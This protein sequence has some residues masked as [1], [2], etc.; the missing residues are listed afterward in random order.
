[1]N[2]FDQVELQ[3]VFEYIN[4]NLGE[5]SDETIDIANSPLYM[6]DDLS[7]FTLIDAARDLCDQYGKLLNLIDTSDPKVTYL[8]QLIIIFIKKFLIFFM[9]I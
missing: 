4:N 1:M 6:D 9:V 8:Q 3:A 2:E 5:F 7:R